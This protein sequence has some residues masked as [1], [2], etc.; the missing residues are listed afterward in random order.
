MI[1]PITYSTY[2]PIMLLNLS[3]KSIKRKS[4]LFDVW[5]VKT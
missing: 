5:L 3:Q 4:M 2:K 1:K